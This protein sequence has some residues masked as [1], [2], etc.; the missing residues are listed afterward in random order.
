L[1]IILGCTIVVSQGVDF[2][3]LFIPQR[4]LDGNGSIQRYVLPGTVR[5]ERSG[6]QAATFRMK[7]FIHHALDIVHDKTLVSS[8]STSNGLTKSDRGTSALERFL[9]LPIKTEK[10]GGVLWA[11]KRIWNGTAFTEDGVWLNSRLL[12]C[13]FAQV[14]VFGIM[15]FFTRVF[16]YQQKEFFYS[17]EE[18]SVRAKIAK[19]EEILY[20][21]YTD[22]LGD[23]YFYFLNCTEE[24][25]GVDLET[26][27]GAFVDYTLPWNFIAYLTTYFTSYE[28]AKAYLQPCFDA[29]PT[30]GKFFDDSYNATSYS[31]NSFKDLVS[32]F[33]ITPGKYIAAAYCG[34]AGGFVAVFYIAVTL[35]PSFVSTVMKYR[36]GIKSTLTNP[37]FLR[38]R[39]AMD[40][41]TVL[42]GSAFWGCFFTATGAFAFVVLL[43]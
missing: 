19:T 23:D 24:V 27:G 38:Y 12:A 14:T 10:V 17:N 2:V 7:Q 13:N 9:L 34:L 36:S 35:I 41:V 22:V 32:D 11:W 15:I 20:G 26:I 25:L 28:E 21:N 33:D 8:L 3:L 31:G 18:N 37:E 1:A 43:V 4:W 29:F 40:T 16:Y 30:I 39:Y 5:Q 6:K 42:L